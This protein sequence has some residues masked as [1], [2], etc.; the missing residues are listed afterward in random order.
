MDI[1]LS[2]T[3]SFFT[4]LVSHH[5]HSAFF[6][7]LSP[8]SC[9]LS[10]P[11]VFCSLLLPRSLFLIASVSLIPFFVCLP[12]LSISLS[13][14]FFFPWYPPFFNHFVTFSLSII[15]VFHDVSL[16]I[17]LSTTLFLFSISFSLF[18]SRAHALTLVTPCSTSHLNCLS[19][20]TSHGLPGRILDLYFSLSLS[21]LYLFFLILCLSISLSPNLSLSP[22]C[23]FLTH[24]A[25]PSLF[26]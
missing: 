13:V 4:P 14:S 25:R 5:H 10:I 20:S 26:K 2:H 17:Y 1:R 6:A 21:L 8:L 16:R 12:L 3:I 19:A 15:S 11:V 18:L 23:S 24:H 9:I 22:S 7:L